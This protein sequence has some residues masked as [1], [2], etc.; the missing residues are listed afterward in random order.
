MLHYW[1]C[2]YSHMKDAVIAFDSSLIAIELNAITYMFFVSSG[3]H[4]FEDKISQRPVHLFKLV[5]NE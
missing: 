1:I 3:T 5:M 4:I 2:I